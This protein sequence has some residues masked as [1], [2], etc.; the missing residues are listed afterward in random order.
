MYKKNISPI[1]INSEEGIF[2]DN[3]HALIAGY[4]HAE[5]CIYLLHAYKS[6]HIEWPV[7]FKDYDIV[8]MPEAQ[9]FSLAKF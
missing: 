4:D 3:M 5:G 7:N 2:I 8:I 1:S 6:V 9:Q